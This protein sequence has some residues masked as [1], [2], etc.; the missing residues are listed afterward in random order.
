MENQGKSCKLEEEGEN[1]LVAYYLCGLTWPVYHLPIPTEGFS[2][3]VYF[4]FILNFKFAL[5]RQF[6]INFQ[7]NNT[8]SLKEKNIYYYL[9]FKEICRCKLYKLTKYKTKMISQHLFCHLS[10]SKNFITQ[11][12]LD[13]YRLIGW[14]NWDLVQLKIF[15][16][17]KNLSNVHSSFRIECYTSIELTYILTCE[18]WWDD[19][20]QFKIRH[21]DHDHK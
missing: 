2:S 5:L 10:Y 9:K 17:E 6:R 18:R 13:L 8:L 19:T 20:W 1:Q 12:R 16:S 14:E 21:K 4:I 3:L 15:L 11:L 7:F